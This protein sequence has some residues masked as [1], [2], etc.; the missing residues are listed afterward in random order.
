MQRFI[1]QTLIDITET[2][3]FRHQPG[4]ELAK[5]Q[6]QNFSVL[7]QTIGLRANP[8]FTQGPRVE[9]QDLK[10][11]YFGSA[12]KGMHNVWTFVF[13]IE[14]IGAFS[15][16]YSDMGLLTTDLHFVPIITG[17]NETIDPKLAVFDTSSSEYRNTVVYTGS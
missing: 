15:D 7:L 10:E 2:K 8:I 1:I 16:Q 11:F 12:Y 3:Q 5:N 17:L 6:Q 14:Y 9:E 13:D 4:Q